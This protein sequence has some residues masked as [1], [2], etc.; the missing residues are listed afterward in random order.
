MQGWEISAMSSSATERCEQHEAMMQTRTHDDVTIANELAETE[1]GIWA[2]ASDDAPTWARPDAIEAPAAT[3]PRP[4]EAAASEPINTSRHNRYD[5]HAARF[6]MIFEAEDDDDDEDAFED[7]DMMDDEEEDDDFED[8]DDDAF[9][10]DEEDDDF[11]DDEED[12][13]DEFFDDD[14][15]E[16]DEEEDVDPFAGGDEDDA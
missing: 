6:W 9:E 14:E 12:E 2:C 16:D 4:G 15:D 1:T 10:D 11:F 3:A 7:D 13:D 5:P 8:D